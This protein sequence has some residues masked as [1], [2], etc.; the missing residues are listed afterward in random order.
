[1]AIPTGGFQLSY[2]PR[3]LDVPSNIGVYDVGAGQQALLRGMQIAKL[4]YG[5]PV[6]EAEKTRNYK[7][8]LARAKQEDALREQ[9]TRTKRAKLLSE[10]NIAPMETERARLGN[11]LA[12]QR[13]EA[14][15]LDLATARA[16]QAGKLAKAKQVEEETAA[17][18]NLPVLSRLFTPSKRTTTQ[19]TRLPSGAL[20]EATETS[21]ETGGDMPY[22]AS[23]EVKT[24]AAPLHTTE[25]MADAEKQGYVPVTVKDQYG[26]VSTRLMPSR[27]TAQKAVF[28]AIDSLDAQADKEESAGNVEEANR[29]RAQA[30]AKI[31]TWR[32]MR[33]P[34]S[35]ASSLQVGEKIRELRNKEATQGLDAGEKA[36]LAKLIGKNKA[37]LAEQLKAMKEGGEQPAAPAA[38]VPSSKPVEVKSKAEFDRLPSGAQYYFE[39]KLYV[40]GK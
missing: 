15:E 10:E 30:D 20:E 2:M 36:E 35:Q 40:K 9:D 31:E 18:G 11:Q 38:A 14:G 24:G 5:D 26:N 8:L 21:I 3:A 17:R 22:V 27:V 37:S 19:V 33:A 29:L 4:A 16:E 13:V 12:G 7:T 1:M 25:E 23:T 28:D 39:G 32:Q 6:G 34:S